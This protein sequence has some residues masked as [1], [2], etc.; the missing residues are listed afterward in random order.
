MRVLVYLDEGVDPR[1]CKQLA[2]YFREFTGSVELVDHLHVR[3]AP[4]WEKTCDLFV[5]PGGRDLP[6]LKLLSRI[7][8]SRLRA[9]VERGGAYVGICAG[10]Y[11]GAQCVEFEKGGPLEVLG[12]RPLA[13][14]PGIAKGPALGLGQFC[15]DSEAGARETHIV[16]TDG[17]TRPVYYN[18]G[19]AFPD[20][21]SFASVKVIGHYVET[22]E[23]AIVH[24]QV[25]QGQALLSGVHPEIGSAS[26]L[27][28]LMSFLTGN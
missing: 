12:K 25:G 13:F 20:A 24:C 2:T 10:A 26:S 1:G 7:G 21:D 14:F 23:P 8:A 27:P 9:F 22:N 6:Y 16:W 11:F 28:L 19:C 3:Y 18:G 4:D 5:M 15:Y 17:K